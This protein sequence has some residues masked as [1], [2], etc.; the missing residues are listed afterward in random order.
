MLLFVPASCC[1]L[2]EVGLEAGEAQ[3]W[4]QCFD[5][6]HETWAKIYKAKSNRGGS[7]QVLSSESPASVW[8]ENPKPVRWR[9]CRFFGNRI[10][11][12]CI[13][14]RGNEIQ[15]ESIKRA[16]IM[17]ERLLVSEGFVECGR[18]G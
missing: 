12:S 7:D 11:M 10:A 16:P 17:D 18:F 2:D 14:Q 6:T 13:G 8:A 9:R 3:V 5:H 15:D 4:L 1:D